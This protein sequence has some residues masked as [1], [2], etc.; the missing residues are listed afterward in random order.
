MVFTEGTPVDYSLPCSHTHATEPFV[1]VFTKSSPRDSL[2]R[3]HSDIP[4]DHSLTCSERARH[5]TIHYRVYKWHAT[6][7]FVAVLTK[8][9][10][11]VHSLPFYKGMPLGHSLSCSQMTRYWTIHCFFSK[12]HTTGSF[13]QP[14][15]YIYHIHTAFLEYGLHIFL[16]MFT[17]ASHMVWSI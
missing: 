8:K 1:P 10:S 4:L 16:F 5:C 14:I 2:Y 11:L 7:Y 9:T 3:V 17:H 13:A 15:Q 6:G 12:G